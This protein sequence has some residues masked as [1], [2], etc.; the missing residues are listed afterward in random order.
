[1]AFTSESTQQI[2]TQMMQ[3]QEN[4]IAS[5]QA[6]MNSMMQAFTDAIKTAI[7]PRQAA[8]HRLCDTR[9]LHNLPTFD[10]TAGKFHDW[11]RRL[12]CN[13]GCWSE[14]LVRMMDNSETSDTP[15]TKEDVR[16]SKGD[17]GI[18]LDKQLL[19]YLTQHTSDQA[20]DLV[21]SSGECG[22]ESWRLLVKRYD[23]RTA[24]SQRA[25]MAKIM[26]AKPCKTIDELERKM[27]EWEHLMR[28]WQK[29]AGKRLEDDMKVTCIIRLCP[30]RLQEHMN[31]ST[32]DDDG[33]DEVRAEVVRQIEKNRASSTPSPKDVGSYE[34]WS[35]ETWCHTHEEAANDE[36][37]GTVSFSTQCF[38]CGGYGHTAAQCP[39]PKPTK[40]K[41]SSK[42]AAKGKGQF[43]KGAHVSKGKG[44]SGTKGHP[45]KGSQ[46][47]GPG[48][49][50][51][52]GK[53]Y[54]INGTCYHCGEFGH[55][56]K[57]CWSPIAANQKGSKGTH[58]ID[59]AIEESIDVGGFDVGFVGVLPSVASASPRLT[60]ATKNAFDVLAEDDDVRDELGINAVSPGS[61]RPDILAR[62]RSTLEPRNQ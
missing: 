18:D 60:I 54:A 44:K 21:S 34:Y 42:G 31:M 30:A 14:L 47:K 50:T 62:L 7:G 28:R 35:D 10:G 2:I 37:I 55:M 20:G 32:R 46:G 15:I 52:G 23:P 61:R 49:A 29:A 45:F 16:S 26:D 40:G 53:G 39:S 13:V 12:R 36:D 48:Q 6:Q 17:E 25:L 27:Q 51:Q 33:Y 22:F 58:S 38:T 56:A 57:D 19:V 41:G 5:Q 8:N 11:A 3:M 24:E 4:A 43:A 59:S 1:M 9:T